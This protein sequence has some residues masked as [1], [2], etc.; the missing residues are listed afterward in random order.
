M[1][2]ETRNAEMGQCLDRQL[3]ALE[4]LYESL[5]LERDAL[6]CRDAGELE[7]ATERKQALLATVGGLEQQRKVLAPDLDRMESFARHPQ[8]AVRWERLLELSRRCRE[9]NESNGRTIRQQRRR[10]ECT[11]EL[12]RGKPVTDDAVYGPD[13]ERS[14]TGSASLSISLV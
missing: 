14:R 6:L 8:L 12:L 5:L 4:Q 11:L 9:Q 7:R 10:V 2:D 3:E 13:G 1:S